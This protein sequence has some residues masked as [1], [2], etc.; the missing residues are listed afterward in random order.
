MGGGTA[1]GCSVTGTDYNDKRN[2]KKTIIILDISILFDH[3]HHPEVWNLQL[4]HQQEAFRHLK[5]KILKGFSNKS[6]LIFT[7]CI[8]STSI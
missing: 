3:Y 4:F 5:Y 7:L 1:L 8:W 6:I 2:I